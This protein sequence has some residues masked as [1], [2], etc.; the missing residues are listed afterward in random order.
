M[1]HHIPKQ[2]LGRTLIL[3]FILFS[4]STDDV[5]KQYLVFKMYGVFEKPSYMGTGETCNDSW[6]EP[7]TQTFLLKSIKMNVYD[8]E[9]DENTIY[10]IFEDEP[11]TIIVSNRS[12]KIFSVEISKEELGVELVGKL[13]TDVAITF[14][15]EITGRGKNNENLETDLVMPNTDEANLCDIVVTTRGCI[16]DGPF[17]DGP[18]DCSALM[19]DNF[20]AE[21]GL[22]YEFLIKVQWKQTV[23]RE[24][25]EKD[26]K[27]ISPTFDV[28]YSKS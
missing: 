27:M 5:T 22:G 18:G 4:C 11:K 12:Q 2:V 17:D 10:P 21:K 9:T 25:E 16:Q 1:N 13:I 14:D 19:E 7:I 24:D 23:Q 20:T 28:S 8:P 6:F 15:R 26:I 3:L